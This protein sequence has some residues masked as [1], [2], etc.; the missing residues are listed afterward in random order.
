MGK[1]VLFDPLFR[2]LVN[3]TKPQVIQIGAVGNAFGKPHTSGVMEVLHNQKYL[4]KEF[5]KDGIPVIWSFLLGTGPA[6]SEGLGN[7]T[8]DFGCYGDFCGVMGK[9]K[10][11]RSVALANG[12][13]GQNIYIVV[14][15]GDDQSRSL[16]DLRGKRVGF[17]KETYLHLEFEKLL[18]RFGLSEKDFK[19]SNLGAGEGAA[20]LLS[21]KL[22]AYVGSAFFLSFRDQGSVRVIYDSRREKEGFKGGKVVVGREDFVRRFPGITRRVVKAYV[23]AADWASREENRAEYLRLNTLTGTPFAA[24]A[25]DHQGDALRDRNNPLLEKFFFDHYSQTVAFS[26]KRG[27]I[28]RSFEV[29]D[30]AR[31]TFVSEAVRELGLENVW[32]PEKE[33]GADRAEGAE[34]T[35]P[36]ADDL[37]KAAGW[38]D[39]SL[40]DR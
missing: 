38:M 23:K 17:L 2:G 26:L 16:E 10:G 32:S 28:Q 33:C 40:F 5:E 7:G 34:G 30:W 27:M 29:R 18:A 37:G 20:A 31:E 22:D 14:P 19:V 13:R 15:A 39:S 9:A 8:L 4:E 1:I 11:I 12:G 3:Q 25:A 36:A 35:E 24:V 21:G 6:I